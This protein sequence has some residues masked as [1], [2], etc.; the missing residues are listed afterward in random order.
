MDNACFDGHYNGWDLSFGA[1][2]GVNMGRTRQPVFTIDPSTG[3]PIGSSPASYNKTDF[4]QKY[5]G[6]YM[7]AVRDRFL[8]DL[9]YRQEWTDFDLEN[10]GLNG[11]DARFG[12]MDQSF[13]SHAHTLSGSFSYVIPVNEEKL[14]NFVPTAGFSFTSTKTDN[15]L[16]SSTNQANGPADGVL[17]I[18]NSD[19]QVGFLGGTLSRTKVDPSGS[20]ALTYFGTATVY[21]DFSPESRSIYYETMADYNN[22]TNGYEITSTNLGTYGEVSLGVNYTKLLDGAGA[23]GGRQLNASARIDGRFGEAQTS[24]GITGQ[25]RLQF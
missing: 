16:L 20:S 25:I 13:G 21:H 2:L 1:T 4:Q 18:K 10:T 6:V 22:G 14:I 23:I 17:V 24:W 5:A 7:T 9:Q 8:M 3:L 12:I 15:V 11:T 19:T